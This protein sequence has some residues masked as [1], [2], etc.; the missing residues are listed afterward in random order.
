MEDKT[1]APRNHYDAGQ[2][3]KPQ[4]K[5][6][7]REV[8]NQG[9]KTVPIDMHLGPSR[10]SDKA[11]SGKALL[12]SNVL[13]QKRET[14]RQALLDSGDLTSFDSN[15]EKKEIIN[16]IIK[17]NNFQFNAV[18]AKITKVSFVYGLMTAELEILKKEPKLQ[19]LPLKPAEKIVGVFRS[20]SHTRNVLTM[21]NT[22][23]LAVFDPDLSVTR[24]SHKRY[25]LIKFFRLVRMGD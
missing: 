3:G 5:H 9:P 7:I 6:T 11:A 23:N 8:E 17:E 12:S 22:H 10:P 13:K 4:E 20:H 18:I 24:A 21:H 16:E 15:L 14:E 25:L 19:H 2:Q 1:F